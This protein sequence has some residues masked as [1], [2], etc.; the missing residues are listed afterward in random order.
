MAELSNRPPLQRIRVCGF[1]HAVPP[2]AQTNDAVERDLEL[3]A[4]WIAKRTG[5]DQRRVVMPDQA[6]SDLA[7]ASAQHSL[8]Q[9]DQAPGE[10]RALVLA[11]ST[12]DHLLPPTAPRVAAEL[13]CGAIPAFDMAV[14]CSGFVYGLVVAEGL[15]RSLNG[16][17]LL[18]AANVLSK[19]VNRRDPATVAL[20][21]DAAGSVILTPSPAAAVEA[22]K[23]PTEPEETSLPPGILASHLESSGEGWNKL[24]IPAGG[25]RQPFDA[26]SFKQQQHLM[27][28]RDGRAVYRYAVERMVGCAEHVLAAAQLSSDQVDWWIPHQ[29]SGRVIDEVTRQLRVS[30]QRVVNVVEQ[31]GNSSAATIPLACSLWQESGKLREGQTMVLTAAGAGLTAGAVVLRT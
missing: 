26:T 14:A 5:I 13:G 24:L 18:I 15:A 31:Y 30:P 11:T 2:Q 3:P 28:I 25:S 10:I 22:T 23:T 7:I 16:P 19:R 21:A 29:A 4:G 20:F 12:P 6:T 1:G 27:E 17:V 8:R 9:A